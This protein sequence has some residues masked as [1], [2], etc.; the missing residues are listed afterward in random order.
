MFLKKTINTRPKLVKCAK[1]L[2]ESGKIIPDT[3]ILDVDVI[4]QNAK[5]Q[6]EASKRNGIDLFFMLKQLG[7]NPYIGKILQDLGYAGA[8][9]VDYKEALL[10]IENNIHI[11]NVGHLVQ[12]PKNVLEK[13]VLSKPEFFTVFSIEIMDEINEICKKH[14]IKQKIMLKVIDLEKD[15]LYEGQ[16]GG[17]EL[18]NLENNFKKFKS[19]KNLDICGLTAFPCILKDSKTGKFG[20]TQNVLTI[21]KAKTT[22]EKN[23]FNIK[24][25]NMPSATSNYSMELLKELGATHGEP[26]HSLTGTTPHHNDILTEEQVAMIY[27]TEVSHSLDGDSYCY[28]GGHYR[29]SHV[30]KAL[31]EGC[32]YKVIPPSDESIDYYFKV[33]GEHVYGQTVVMNFRTQIFVT[34]SNVALVTGIENENPQI[35]DIYDS[36][37][38]L[39]T[40][41]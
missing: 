40:K 41:E 30:D 26:G 3:Y 28:G 34:R 14:K 7:R 9:V 31:I 25:M 29:R 20:E 6:L 39:C 5:S 12:T 8:V 37:G 22:L 24:F 38:N 35:I 19:Y 32:L 16:Y 17:F 33:K 1:E 27:V 11:G 10:M 15:F 36:Q 21:K 23:G 2:H 4:I 18:K 13:I